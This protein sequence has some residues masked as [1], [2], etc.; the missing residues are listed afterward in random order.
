MDLDLR[1]L[2]HLGIKLYS[3]AAAVLS[4]AV[5][6]SWDADSTRVT[7]DLAGDQ[8]VIDDNGVGMTLKHINE[9]FL[10]VGYDKRAEEGEKSKKGRSFMGRKGIGKLSLFS[11]AEEIEVRTV[12]D[13]EH[14]AFRM[15]ADAIRSAIKAR[16]SYRPEPIN[17]DSRRKGTQIVLRELKKR[18]TAQTASA[19]R[20]RIARRFSIIGHKSTTGDKF[21]VLIDGKAIGP[22]DREDFKNIEFLWEFED[23]ERIPV[24][25]LPSVKKRFLLPTEVRAGKPGWTIRGWLGAVTRPKQLRHDEAG[26]MNGI[27]VIAR[28]RL[29]QE[30]ILD[31]LNFSRIFASYITGQVEADFLD[32]P[33]EEDIATSDRQRLIEDDER[34]EALCTFL[35]T[36]LVSIADGWTLLRN[37]ARG[38]EAVELH[39]PLG[40]WVEGLPH[41]QR[42]PA[43]RMLGVIQSV[44][45]EDEVDR[46]DLYRASILAFE[47]LRLRGESHRLS[48]LPELT[49][50]ELLPLLSDLAS[51]EGALYRD[52][53]RSRI[54]V[55]RKFENL[56]DDNAKE[57]VLQE[58]LFK[59]LW[60]LDPGW[61][62]ATG[63]ERIEAKLRAEYKE[64]RPDL[65]DKESKG[66]VDITYRTNGGEHIIVELK[67]AKRVLSVPELQEQGQKYVGALK[68]CLASTGV[69]NPHISVVFVVGRAVTEEE[70][71]SF[72]ADYVRKT[73]GTL[74]ARVEQ[75][76]R[77]I[78]GARASYQEYLERSRKLDHTESLLRDL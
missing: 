7:I 36:T 63:S 72:G 53:V 32:V 38:K 43:Q 3:N 70:N 4:E 74:N 62:R 66:R 57:K 5:A 18:R 16:K 21:D 46:R 65:S 58:H 47:R 24:A 14:H 49:A 52:I 68:K 54:D 6:N 29:I 28:G 26:A 73:L 76:E 48:E 59:N 13:G 45:L 10:Y 1:V 15:R 50:Q 20:K 25:S 42:I 64:F 60:L 37:E 8:V 39:P 23:A 67:R 11:V 35:R 27:V 75:Y 51:L 41:G 17:G 22:G 77:L 19:L 2:E 78:S 31:K 61:E 44:E 34:Y 55:I 33:G 56:V 30:N 9:R 71:P 40:R 12:R 69:K